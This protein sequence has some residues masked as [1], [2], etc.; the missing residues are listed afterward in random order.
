MNLVVAY[1]C[2]IFGSSTKLFTLQG[3]FQKNNKKLELC[4]EDKVEN[5]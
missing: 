2:A 1:S 4:E 3:Q 5:C